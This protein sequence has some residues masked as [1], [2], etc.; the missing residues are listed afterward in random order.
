MPRYENKQRLRII[1]VAANFVW[2]KITKQPSLQIDCVLHISPIPNPFELLKNYG[3]YAYKQKQA[4]YVDII[5][6]SHEQCMALFS[7]QRSL[8]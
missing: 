1:Q 6:G 5:G 3:L 7:R 8:F 2:P 4:T